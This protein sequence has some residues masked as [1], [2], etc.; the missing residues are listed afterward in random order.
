MED[1]GFFNINSDNPIGFNICVTEKP[2]LYHYTDLKGL[3]GILESGCFWVSRSDSLNDLSEINYIK[4][5]LKSA[6]ELLIS[7]FDKYKNARFD[8]KGTLLNNLIKYIN[9][10]GDKFSSSASDYDI[11]VLSLSENVESLALFSNYSNGNGCNIGFDFS[12]FLPKSSVFMNYCGCSVT[13]GKVIYDFEQQITIIIEDILNL[14]NS[15]SDRLV[16]LKIRVFNQDIYNKIFF[17]IMNV[18]LIKTHIY[19]LFFKHFTFFHEEEYRYA[20]IVPNEIGRN[21]VKHRECRSLKIPY[22][23][24]FL[25]KKLPITSIRLA[26]RCKLDINEVF[27]I[28]HHYNYYGATVGNSIIP[29]R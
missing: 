5:I 11:F 27:E 8:P 22:I 17:D 2:V 19:A 24:F 23:E 16:E 9:Y 7:D 28:L 29:I 4:I 10:L 12:S 15:V 26:P 14:Y 25:N 1:F 18:I 20:F 21:I 13:S 6:C 3:K